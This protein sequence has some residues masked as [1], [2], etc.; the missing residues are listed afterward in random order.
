MWKEDVFVYAHFYADVANAKV[1]KISTTVQDVVTN[2]PCKYSQ[3]TLGYNPH[4][5]HFSVAGC[6]GSYVFWSKQKMELQGSPD[7]ARKHIHYHLSAP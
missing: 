2:C 7:L 1:G 5:N 4:G 3:K 6:T